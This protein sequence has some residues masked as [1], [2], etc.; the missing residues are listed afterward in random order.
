MCV[1]RD[2][3]LWNGMGE[4]RTVPRVRGICGGEDCDYI[5]AREVWVEFSSGYHFG[6]RL[7]GRLI[8]EVQFD[9]PRYRPLF[10]I[11]VP[12]LQILSSTPISTMSRFLRGRVMEEIV[13][14]YEENL[15]LTMPL[16][17]HSLRCGRRRSPFSVSLDA[18]RR[19][20]RTGKIFD[21]VE[22]SKRH[23]SYRCQRSCE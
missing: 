5:S 2:C 11:E 3:I 15:G 19:A 17:Y 9:D 7:P 16:F 8:S 14:R 12:S 21:S 23:T 22:L 4:L 10:R 1:L 18:K 13:H 20:T 6:N